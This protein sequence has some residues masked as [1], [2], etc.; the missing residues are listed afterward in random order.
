MDHNPGFY[1]RAAGDAIVGSAPNDR[2]VW[3]PLQIFGGQSPDLSSSF[4]NH[5]HKLF[6][7]RKVGWV[8]RGAD[9]P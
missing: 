9:L 5:S 1:C 6:P 8:K 3:P 7:L 4:R 2:L